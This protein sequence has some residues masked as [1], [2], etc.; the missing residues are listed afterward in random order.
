[1]FGDNIT[2]TTDNTVFVP[3]IRIQA[4]KQIFVGTG[5]TAST[6]G[7]ITLTAGTAVVSTTKIS[8][9][10][11]VNLTIQGG[12]VTDVGTPYVSGRTDGASFT[13]KS[14]NSGDTSN[15]GW[16]IFEQY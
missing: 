3:D 16:I 13:I 15:V 1:V 6:A 11:L 4:Q 14:T 7:V 12:T 8:N 5:G 10:S 9:N 2:G